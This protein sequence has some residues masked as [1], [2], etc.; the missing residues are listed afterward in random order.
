MQFVLNPWRRSH[1]GRK[2]RVLA[3]ILSPITRIMLACGFQNVDYAYVHGPPGRLRLGRGCSTMNTFFNVV[4]GE[5]HVGDDTLFSHNCQ[6]LT[7]IH[8]FENGRRVALSGGSLDDEVPDSGRNIA[9]G[10]GCFIGAGVV[11]LGGVT[12]GDDVIIGA[13]A[14]VTSDIPSGSFA[15]GVPAR[16]RPHLSQPTASPRAD[17]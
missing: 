15:A 13:G 14:V 17:H 8:R 3:A 2:Q 6:V 11:I 9:L 12:I 4:S 10:S 1:R 5:V 7:G 16:A